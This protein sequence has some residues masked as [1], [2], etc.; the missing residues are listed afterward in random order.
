MV[1]PVDQRTLKAERLLTT[2]HP[3]SPSGNPYTKAEAAREAGISLS[4][5]YYHINKQ[6]VAAK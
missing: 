1:R 5:L 3:R 4:A 6:K 2:P